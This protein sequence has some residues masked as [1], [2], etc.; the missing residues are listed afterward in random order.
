MINFHDILLHI[1]NA[2]QLG[3]ATTAAGMQ[4]LI[5]RMDV[6][7]KD[8]KQAWLDKS[9]NEYAAR[10]IRIAHPDTLGILSDSEVERR[11]TTEEF[12]IQKKGL[13]EEW[14]N[15]HRQF[16][17]LTNLNEVFPPK[18][19]NKYPHNTQ[20]LIGGDNKI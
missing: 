17:A 6:H 19:L 7:M 4:D 10:R 9:A 2:T 12:K 1:E 15:Y 20:N 8:F 16:E 5:L 11:F 14:C 3:R 18:N 13:F